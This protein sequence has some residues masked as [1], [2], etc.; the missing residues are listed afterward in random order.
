MSPTI[1][2]TQIFRQTHEVEPHAYLT[3]LFTNLPAASTA[4]HF[5]ALLPW[6]VKDSVRQPFRN[7]TLPP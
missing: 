6:N 5:E 3:Y 1:A 2:L 4:D 7:L